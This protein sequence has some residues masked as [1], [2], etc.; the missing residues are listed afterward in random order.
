RIVLLIEQLRKLGRVAVY[1]EGQLG[2]VVRSDRE[3]VEALCERACEHDVRR[4]LAHHI[5]LKV[6]AAALEP[7]SRHDVEYAIGLRDRAAERDHHDHVVEAER[8]AEAQNRAA[9]ESETVA[10]T[11]RV[12]AR[13][14]AKAEHRVLLFRLELGAAD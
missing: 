3:T 7:V 6:I 9:L 14:S 13:G 8:L 11:R 2:Q 12:V 1:A 10:V 4:N 5:N